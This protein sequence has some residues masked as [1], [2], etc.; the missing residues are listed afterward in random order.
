MCQAIPRR[1]LSVDRERIEVDCDGR[2]LAVSAL[3]LPGLS[4]GD[5]VL[6]YAGQALERLEAAEAEALLS[7]YADLAAAALEASA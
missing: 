5:Y 4:V 2:P 3:G 1:V 7:L 6:V